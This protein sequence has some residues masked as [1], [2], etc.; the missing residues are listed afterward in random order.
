MLMTWSKVR[1]SFCNFVYD[2]GLLGVILEL[3]G[4][5]IQD[6]MPK[7]RKR[8]PKG[9]QNGGSEAPPG[10]PGSHL[11]GLWSHIGPPK[12]PAGVTSGSSSR[13]FGPNADLWKV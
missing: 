4:D 12:G 7:G 6:K 10:L 1:H 9:R 13:L 5:L 2:F 11:G 3:R 8:L